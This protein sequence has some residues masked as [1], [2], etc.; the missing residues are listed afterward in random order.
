MSASPDLDLLREEV[1]ARLT[2]VRVATICGVVLRV[3]GQQTMG[4][5][6]CPFHAEKSP[7]FVAGGKAG[8][9]DKFVCWGCGEKGDIFDFWQKTQ[10]VDHLQ[11]VK[12]LAR[13]AGIYVGEIGFDT[14]RARPVRQVERRLAE[15]DD[16][17]F[18]KPS[19]PVLQ[20]PSREACE[21]IAMHRGLDAEAV[22]YAARV[23]GRVGY[24]PWP[25]YESRNDGRWYERRGWNVGPSWAAMD[26]TLNV[27]EFRRLDNGLYESEDGEKKMKCWSA[28]KKA[29]PVGA[30]DAARLKWVLMVEGGPDMLAGYHFL[31]LHKMLGKVAVVCMLGAGNA[32]REDALPLFT[33]CRVRIMVDADVPK[34]DAVKTKRKMAGQE[35]AARWSAQLSEAGAAVET[36]CVGDTYDR[37]HVVEWHE[38][39]RAAAD[40]AKVNEGW[41]LKDGKPVKDLN[42]VALCDDEVIWSQDMREAM[43]AWDF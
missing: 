34:D 28:G 19:L 37:A 25:L 5:G 43:R 24:S 35:A 20:K 7:S 23:C 15:A 36:F 4:T 1:R 16:D 3:S 40:I 31:R 39:E 41:K 29:W 11:A 6:L 10:G 27:V 9:V 22:W 14:S 42:D 12:D 26:R 2:M 33:G 32:I 17:R 18:A 21:M 30:L 13:E 8:F 38:G